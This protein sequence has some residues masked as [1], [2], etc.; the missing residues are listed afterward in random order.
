MNRRILWTNRTFMGGGSSMITSASHQKWY[1]CSISFRTRYRRRNRRSSTGSILRDKRTTAGT[2][3]MQRWAPWLSP[4]KLIHRMDRT[5]KTG[6]QVREIMQKIVDQSQL[7]RVEITNRGVRAKLAEKSRGTS[8]TWCSSM[9]VTKITSI[10]S[11]KWILI[12]AGETRLKGITAHWT[13][14]LIVKSLLPPLI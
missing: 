6:K 1:A 9:K 7:R 5:V 14:C 3:I 11:R 13:L 8:T 10:K 12:G 2:K 4:R